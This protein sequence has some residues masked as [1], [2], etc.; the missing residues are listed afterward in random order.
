MKR[1]LAIAGAAALVAVAL[2][3]RG[4]LAGDDDGS[5]GAG[6]ARPVVACSPGLEPICDAL[7]DAGFV[8]PGT[9]SF[10]LG[11]T[12]STTGFVDDRR[13]DAWITWD[14]AGPMA[15]FDV[16]SGEPVWAGAEAVG[17]SPV[18]LAAKQP[19][20]G[21]GCAAPMSW[22]CVVSSV[23]GGASVA[24]GRIGTIDGVVRLAPI[25]VSTL[26]DDETVQ[27]LDVSLVRSVAE[28]STQAPDD[29]AAELRTFEVRAG[30]YDVI[31]GPASGLDGVVGATLTTPTGDF[32]MTLVVTPRSVRRPDGSPAFDAEAVQEAV[33]AA[34]VSPNGR[35]GRRATCR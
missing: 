6:G 1:V 20:D 22:T 29:F 21:E 3:V 2:V 34:G 28:S 12:A 7:A 8:D 15:N 10:D 23:E 24:V 33:R 25:A 16:A 14:P 13:V 5:S 4:V 9:E 32:A 35:T 27:D 11:S 30:A 18:A 19:L 17:S 26:S 31:V